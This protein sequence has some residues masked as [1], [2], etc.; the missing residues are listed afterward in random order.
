MYCIFISNF[1]FKGKMIFVRTFLLVTLEHTKKSKKK[2]QRVT[3]GTN[4]VKAL[5]G[6]SKKLLFLHLPLNSFCLTL[7]ICKCLTLKTSP[8]ISRETRKKG[9]K[10]KKILNDMSTKASIQVFISSRPV[11]FLQYNRQFFFV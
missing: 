10:Y 6:L 7:T 8:G 5:Y 11:Y 1:I 9:K 4:R 2:F 3:K